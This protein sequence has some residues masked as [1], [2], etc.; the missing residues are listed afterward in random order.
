MLRKIALYVD[1][2]D[3]D[4]G[5]DDDH[6]SMPSISTVSIG[7]NVTN[8]VLQNN[9]EIQMKRYVKLH[10]EEIKSNFNDDY[11]QKFPS[12]FDCLFSGKPF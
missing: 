12:I 2:D 9:D 6:R 5:D 8:D 1:D 4:N 11:F 3:D 10:I 7:T